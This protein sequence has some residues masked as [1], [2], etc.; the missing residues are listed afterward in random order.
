MVARCSNLLWGSNEWQHQHFL[1]G[2][3]C[4][5]KASAGRDWPHFFAN[6]LLRD[7]RWQRDSSAV[8]FERY[9]NVR[10]FEW[11]RRNRIALMWLL[12]LLVQFLQWTALMNRLLDGFRE[13][14]QTFWGN[15]LRCWVAI[16]LYFCIN[17]G[18]TVSLLDFKKTK[19]SICVSDGTLQCQV[20]GLIWEG[21]SENTVFTMVLCRICL[22]YWERIYLIV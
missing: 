21:V 16:T 10:S 7:F 22:I 15:S 2:N 14:K 6:G 3:T 19:E 12:W 4:C 18:R 20:D 1:G 8:R 13:R 5:F 9:P 11:V 17:G